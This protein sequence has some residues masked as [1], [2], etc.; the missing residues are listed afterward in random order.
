MVRRYLLA[1]IS[2]ALII[3]SCGGQTAAPSTSNL[4]VLST[5]NP[6]GSEVI[7]IQTTTPISTIN[8]PFWGV[9]YSAYWDPAQGSDGSQ[10]ALKNAGIQVIRFPGGEPA[11]YYDWKNPYA[12]DWSKTSTDDL[13]KYAQ[14][15][16]AQ[17]LLQTNPTT[18]HNNNPSGAHAAEWVRYT[19]DKGMTTTYWEVGNEPDLKMTKANDQEFLDWYFKAFE[20]HGKAMK[21]V[22]PDLKLFGPVGT[23]AYQWWRLGSLDLFMARFGNKQGNGLVD[24]IS[25]HYYPSQGCTTWDEFKTFPQDWP[26]FMQQIKSVI[27]KYDSRDL[28]VF[29]SET[30]V[31]GAQDCVSTQQVGAALGNADLLGA[32]RNSGV[33]AV[34]LFGSIHTSKYWGLLY[35]QGED[36]PLDSPTPTYFILPLWTKSGNQ[37]L[38]VEGL[39]NPGEKIS[40]YASRRESGAIQVLVINKT[41]IETPLTINF[42]GYDPKGKDVMIS[43]MRAANGRADDRDVIYNGVQNPDV[44]GDGLPSPAIRP[45]NSSSYNQ[46]LPPYSISVFEFKP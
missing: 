42:N 13:W 30:N 44:T 19:K 11:N 12:D 25:L 41:G 21:Q 27:A 1:I 35:G 14:G 40:A 4:P 9:N 22:N 18:E 34:Q 6:N 29:I 15:V 45:V 10:K 38:A 31:T 16:G 23:N 37:V 7:T 17:L 33:Q 43:E 39:S 8:H 28:P 46:I 24:G 26:R 32:Y 5:G 3:A 2:C 20:D 36:R